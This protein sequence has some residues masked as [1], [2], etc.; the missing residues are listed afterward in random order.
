M[1]SIL[2][3]HIANRWNALHKWQL[4]SD[5]RLVLFHL[6]LTSLAKGIT[7]LRL[8][9][10]DLFVCLANVGR[11]VPRL[12]HDYHEDTCQHYEEF[13]SAPKNFQTAH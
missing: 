10:F 7:E 6:L 11:R 3:R 5:A 9:R 2:R 1:Y 12:T 4:A 13:D 8:Y